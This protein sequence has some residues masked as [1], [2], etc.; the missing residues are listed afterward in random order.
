MANHA[1]VALLWPS[2]HALDWY[3][4]TGRGRAAIVELNRTTPDFAHLLGQEA[5]IDGTLYRCRGV[6]RFAHCPPW[7]KGEKVSLLVESVS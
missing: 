3:T 2:F 5:L 4:I 6:E 7:H 1:A